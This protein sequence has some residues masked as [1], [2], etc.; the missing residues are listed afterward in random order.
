MK[1]ENTDSVTDCEHVRQTSE[2]LKI[3]PFQWKVLNR[4]PSIFSIEFFFLHNF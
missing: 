2:M 4:F 3:L 1:I